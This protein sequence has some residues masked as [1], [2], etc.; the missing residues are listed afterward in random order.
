[1]SV[2]YQSPLGENGI[3]DTSK[4]C[5]AN[6]ESAN[7][8]ERNVIAISKEKYTANSL[9]TLDISTDGAK[10][11]TATGEALNKCWKTNGQDVYAVFKLNNI[12][13]TQKDLGF[14]VVGRIVYEYNG[15]YYT[16]YSPV[17]G[18]DKDISAQSVYDAAFASTPNQGWFK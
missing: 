8:V 1:M 12:K 14:V 13:S 5:L 2:K 17:F 18:A 7:I 11:S 9:T 15:T 16:E 3:A 10:H 4:I 6:G